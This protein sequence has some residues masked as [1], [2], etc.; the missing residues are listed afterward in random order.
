MMAAKATST[1][2]KIPLM[3]CWKKATGLS[4]KISESSAS[5]MS[6]VQVGAR[7]DEST[8]SSC[9]GSTVAS[10][11]CTCICQPCWAVSA[12]MT[13]V[14]VHSHATCQALPIRSFLIMHSLKPCLKAQ[15]DCVATLQPMITGCHAGTELL[16]GSLPETLPDLFPK[17]AYMEVRGSGLEGSVPSTWFRNDSWPN[18]NSFELIDNPNLG[19]EQLRHDAQS[20]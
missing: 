19:G 17:L 8:C 5:R 6:W 3:W 15:H 10:A 1:A 11:I 7:A 2:L 20:A 14:F 12:I 16:R 4:L 9:V 13:Y 18:L